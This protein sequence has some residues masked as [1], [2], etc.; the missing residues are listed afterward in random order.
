MKYRA[1]LP[2][3]PSAARTYLWLIPLSAVL[4]TSIG[5]IAAVH[6]SYAV[7]LFAVALSPIMILKVPFEYLYSGLLFLGSG[8]FPYE[9]FP[10]VVK[11]GG[12]G[13]FPI[14][15]L[16]LILVLRMIIVDWPRFGNPLTLSPVIIPIVLYLAAVAASVAISVADGTAPLHQAANADRLECLF[17]AV[18]VLIFGLRDMKQVRRLLASFLLLSTGIS[19]MYAL[20]FVFG[21]KVDLFPGAKILINGFEEA[22][23]QIRNYA[24]GLYFVAAILIASITMVQN[25]SP[26]KRSLYFVLALLAFGQAA[27]S[28]TRAVWYG[29][30]AGFVVMWLL[31]RKRE[32][33]GYPILLGALASAFALAVTFIS[34]LANARNGSLIDVLVARLVSP[35]TGTV[36]TLDSRLTESDAAWNA[37]TQSPLIGIGAGKPLYFDRVYDL[38]AGI[39]RLVPTYFLHNGYIWLLADVGII[40]TFPLLLALGVSVWRALS[41]SVRAT[42]PGRRILLLALGAGIVDILVQSITSNR[43]YD[44]S[45]EMTLVTLVGVSE[46]IQRMP[47]ADGPCDE[48]QSYALASPALLEPLAVRPVSRAPLQPELDHRPIDCTRRFECD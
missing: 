47:T 26:A 8:I 11:F 45:G 23:G 22:Q 42:T 10:E 2:S 21:T 39:E 24:G 27:L 18:P 3:T 7:M 32:R 35:V 44:Y 36:K 28:F 37:F 17:L 16:L 40:G 13:L 38:S 46:A 19:V 41:A 9:Y 1:A 30:L 4:E 15:V 34:E 43:F 6:P 5:V 20:Q 48:N 31:G 14:E 29:T 25:I 12:T 33:I